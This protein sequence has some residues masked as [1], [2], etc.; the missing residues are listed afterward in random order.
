MRFCRYT[1][2]KRREIF[3]RWLSTGELNADE[4]KTYGLSAWDDNTNREEFSLQATQV[5]GELSR[6]DQPLI[7]VF[8]QLEGL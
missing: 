8:D 3:R 7:L 6:L 1:D 5:F 2:P 4:S